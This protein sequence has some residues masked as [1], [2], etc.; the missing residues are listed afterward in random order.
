MTEPKALA[1][2]TIEERAH[3]LM[4]AMGKVGAKYVDNNEHT[5]RFSFNRH[6]FDSPM[7][8]DVTIMLNQWNVLIHGAGHLEEG[9]SSG[10]AADVA[11][12]LLDSAQLRPTRRD[13]P[14]CPV[15]GY[16]NK[17]FCDEVGHE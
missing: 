16:E 11:A 10:A 6:G 4:L 3:M 15:C 12:W 13:T 5:I 14:P 9:H 8:C 1:D 17:A 7:L 2:Y